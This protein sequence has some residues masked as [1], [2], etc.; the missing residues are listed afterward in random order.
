MNRVIRGKVYVPAVLKVVEFDV[1]GPRR[2]ELIRHDETV[3]LKGEE[4]F[5]I[6]YVPE[7]MLKRYS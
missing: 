5:W 2:F 3:N 1:S 6:V 7:A 4:Q